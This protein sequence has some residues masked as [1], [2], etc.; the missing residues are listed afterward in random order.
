M[1][2]YR[3]EDIK[4]SVVCQSSTNRFTM[5]LQSKL[6]ALPLDVVTSIIQFCTLPT[7]TRFASASVLADQLVAKELDIRRN[8]LL[9]RFVQDQHAFSQKLTELHSIVG[10]SAAVALCSARDTFRPRDLDM[11]VPAHVSE[12]W[13]RYL[14]VYE[15]Y[16][17]RRRV[18]VEKEEWRWHHGGTGPIVTLE[19]GTTS[20]DII[21][22]LAPCAT[23]PIPYSWSTLMTTFMTGVG[24]VSPYP[25]LLEE[26]RGLVN[27]DSVVYDPPSEGRDPLDVLLPRYKSRGF[28]IRYGYLDWDRETNPAATC[29]GQDVPACPETIRWV[30]DWHTLVRRF[31]S[32]DMRVGRSVMEGTLAT[33]V[34]IWR[35]GGDPCGPSCSA[36]RE[37]VTPTVLCR[38]ADLVA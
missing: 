31:G 20:I 26:R 30:G 10:G 9:A 19:R 4:G 17:V 23:L 22:S 15:G 32:V 36:T 24:I 34:A 18:D 35:W 3:V 27:P 37:Y 13:V 11:Y 38:S 8:R 14:T 29:N 12:V 16:R 28:D 2:R 33:T 25:R 1:F 7:L 5:P 6:P 21:E